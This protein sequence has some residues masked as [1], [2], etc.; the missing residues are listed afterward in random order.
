MKSKYNLDRESRRFS[1]YLF[2]MFLF[3]FYQISFTQV[4]ISNFSDFPAYPYNS[5]GYMQGGA[6]VG[7]GPTTG[8]MILGYFHHVE[9]MSSASG[10][11]D[12]PVSGV[13]E[14]LSTAWILHGSTY[15]NTQSNGFGSV[16]NIESGLES[17][18]ENKG[19]NI[20]VMIHAS[21]TYDPNSSAADWLNVY[22]PYGESWMNDGYFWRTD[23]TN[24]WF[25][26]NDF[27][28]FVE[29]KISSGITIFLSIDTNEDREGDH[30]VPLVG[31]DRTNLRYAYYDT[32]DT[33]IHWADIHYCNA[34]GATRDN[35][36]S[37]LRSISYE[38]PIQQDLRPAQ[39]L[40]VLSGY[41]NVVP[42]AWNSPDDDPTT[43]FIGYNVYRSTNSGGPFIRIANQINRLYYRDE[44]AVNGQNYYY[45]ITAVYTEGESGPSN[46]A[47][48]T[49]QTGGYRV[50]A[51][52]AATTP[53]I[54]GVINAAEWATATRTSVL[55]PGQAGTVTMMVMND[56]NRLYIAIDNPRDNVV[57]DNDG[58]GA[59][60]DENLD[61]AWPSSSP[62]GEGLIQMFSQAGEPV[63]RYQGL[64]GTWPDQYG[65]DSYTTPSGVRH[66]VSF[67]SGH[68]QIETSYDL[69]LSP[70][71]AS[72]GDAIGMLF[73]VMDA[74][75]GEF[76]GLWPQATYQLQAITEN[77]TWAH[78]PFSYGTIELA[79]F[80][81]IPDIAVEP[82]EWN[83]GSVE[84][85]SYLDRIFVVRNEGNAVLH[86]GSTGLSGLDFRHF[87]TI[88]GGTFAVEPGE[89]HNVVIRFNPT[90]AGNKSAVLA[91]NSD[92]LDERQ[93]QIDLSGTG[94][95]VNPPELFVD[96]KEL[97]FGTA[98]N[99]MTFLINNT[100]GEVLNWRVSEEPEKTWIT[101]VSP[102]SG[103]NEAIITVNVD[104]SL[105]AANSDNGIIRVSSNGGDHDVNV[106]IEKLL[107]V[108]PDHW[109]FTEN[110][111][112]S[113]T[114][115]LPISVNPNI[116]G[117]PLLSGDYIGVF[118]EA[119]L[120]CG[121]EMWNNQNISITVWGDND[122]TRAVDG[123]T[124]G[125]MI[126]YRV[127][128]LSERKEWNNVAV[129]YSQG[130]GLYSGNAYMVLSKFD[131][132]N[133]K[134][135]SLRFPAGWNMFSYNILAEDASASAIMSDVVDD[136]VILKNGVG[137]SYIP[138]YG[139]NQIGNLNFKDGYLGYFS[140]QTSL[141][142]SGQ[143]VDPQTPIE[144]ASG[145]S[146]ISYLPD[147]SIDVRQALETLA[148]HLIIAKDG[149]GNSFIPEYGINQIGNMQ[150]GSGYLL[151]LRERSTL[152]YPAAS[153]NIPGVASLNK[154]SLEN[155]EVEHFQFC[156]M[157]GENATIV[158]PT[159]A[160]PRYPD[161]SPL[162]SGDEIGVFTSAGIC[163]GAVVWE[164]VN[165][166]ITVWGDD[167]QTD[168]V[169]GFKSG[170]TMYYRIWQKDKDMEYPATAV[171]QENNP[172]VYET[173]G[174]S[175]L[176][177]LSVKVTDI[178]FM[179]E[180]MSMSC[181]LEQNYPNPFNPVTVISWQ[182]AVGSHVDL[183]IYNV[184]G[185][186]V[187]TLV[188][189][190]QPAG[191]YKLEWDASNVT[192][193][194]YIYRL[195]AGSRVETRRMILMR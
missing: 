125:E 91:I 9:N 10:L 85:G 63:N 33:G 161:D 163:C 72:P 69:S 189:K 159:E 16:Y 174:Y 3:L 160:N 46:I 178:E 105:L 49:A 32:Y 135:I 134:T 23:G 98:I 179:H 15:M 65:G 6:Y 87:T 101:S 27:C 36:I 26:A 148:A 96:K 120:C 30:W 71:N 180:S 95:I 143:P 109:T 166:A 83:Y 21:T 153:S 152:T 138:E 156:S 110:T 119:G 38:G 60:C 84:V 106:S 100:G 164:G 47:L 154:S 195:Q 17:Y 41:H 185:Q 37:F 73:Y 59:F 168:E 11:L 8:A 121:Y 92:D 20:K 131:V 147:A 19:Y 56:N 79:S 75:A 140:A 128:R 77:Y 12:D 43:T 54:N 150:L 122:Q 104:R 78:G 94:I 190:R 107:P 29:D 118:T 13:N 53:T 67:N 34:P 194:V 169:D 18:A 48:G 7:C 127:C 76:D 42:F 115:V 66:M 55:F 86:V 103:S 187:A 39:N 188:N 139:I 162:E 4:Y 181:I 14:G 5:S 172:I 186:K 35:S 62:S 50:E 89:S 175:V 123:F 93:V 191:S 142:I 155:T 80:T 146:M 176:E 124:G 136:L 183:S 2:W 151:Y 45:R 25:D 64:H 70:F 90:T 133:E 28:D 1:P 52:W 157:T 126:D 31:F 177:D 68:M 114:V 112:N 130:S 40:I 74:N 141:E 82:L 113:A 44:S 165:T 81:G 182:L 116:E 144:L 171:Y 97:N 57:S 102:G 158:V 129:S 170:D 173:N 61:R 145:W 137:E 58:I 117:T 99:R 193:G 111:G 88:S 192:S 51:G 24:W 149:N 108:L 184:L 167:T 22:G 132:F